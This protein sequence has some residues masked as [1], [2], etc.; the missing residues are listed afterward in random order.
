MG[1]CRK[2][3]GPNPGRGR[4]GGGDGQSWQ[5]KGVEQ[6]LRHALD[7]KFRHRPGAV[8]ICPKC[9][10]AGSPVRADGGAPLVR[11]GGKIQGGANSWLGI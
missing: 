8:F 10:Q 5:K 4:V 9:S 11:V 3:Q 6:V 1:G 7:F 2:T